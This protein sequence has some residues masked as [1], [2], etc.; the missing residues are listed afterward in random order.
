MNCASCEHLNPDAARFCNR[1]GAAL[2]ISCSACS[3]PNPPASRFCNHCGTP[4][5]EPA[6][7]DA[8]APRDYTPKHLVE[9]ILRQKAAL[10]GERKHVTVLF[11]DLAD[12]TELAER[13]GPEDMHALMDRAFQRILAQVHRY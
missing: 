6:A 9:K 10:E 7:E 1:C 2:E 3:Q 8:P 13:L 4:L 5:A 12:S 11:A